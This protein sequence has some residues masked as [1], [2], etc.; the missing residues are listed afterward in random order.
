MTGYVARRPA[1]SIRLVRTGI[2]V[3]VLTAGWLLGGTVGWAT[4][5]YAV[6]IGPLAHV[7]IPLFS[8][9]GPAVEPVGTPPV[10]EPDASPAVA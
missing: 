8:V 6:A 9:R 2:E 4:L 10:L 7:F 5:L 3:T 1:R